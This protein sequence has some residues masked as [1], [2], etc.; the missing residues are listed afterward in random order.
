VRILFVAPRYH[1]NQVP[2]VKELLEAG[3]DVRYDVLFTG[4]SEDH[5]LVVPEVV[6]A[7]WWSKLHRRLVRPM[8]LPTYHADHTMPGFLMYR[9]RLAAM[10]PD[11]VVIRDPNRPFSVI[12]AMAARSLGVRLVLYTQGAVHG[13]PDQLKR[14]SR[15]LLVTLF[16]APWYSPNPGNRSFPPHHQDLHYLPFAADLTRSTKKSWFGGGRINLLAVGK[17]VPR[18]NHIMLVR[19]LARLRVKHDVV[20]TLIGEVSNEKHRLHLAEVRRTIDDLGL[21]SAV[22]IYTN[23]PYKEMHQRFLDHDVFVLASRDEPIGVSVLEAMAHA[24]PVVCSTTS[25]ARWYV[26]NGVSGHV[27]KSDDEWDLERALSAVVGDRVGLIAMGVQ[28]RMLCETMY[29]PA[30]VR[31]SFERLAHGRRAGR[32]TTT[33]VP[34]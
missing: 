18:K 14:L 16:D 19:T 17:F 27:F 1:T 10:A 34:S 15:T 4:A 9:R 32:A 11:V 6:H 5:A 29:H 28:G 3:H 8:D 31:R 13:R 26:N 2:F 24:L 20:L 30:E 23:V 22:Q 33:K 7:S 25:G 21:G 12:A